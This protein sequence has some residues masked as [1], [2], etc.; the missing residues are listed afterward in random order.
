VPLVVYD[1]GFLPCLT[2][3]CKTVRRQPL[4]YGVATATRPGSQIIRMRVLEGMT[5]QRPPVHSQAPQ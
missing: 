3:I 1:R 5:P 4:A 2:A